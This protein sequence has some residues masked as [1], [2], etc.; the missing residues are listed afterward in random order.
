[1]K[2]IQNLSPRIVAMLAVATVT[3]AAC[4]DA[5]PVKQGSPEVAVTSVAPRAGAPGTR[6]AINGAGFGTNAGNVHVFVGGRQ[7]TVIS[8]ADAAVLVEIPIDAVTGEMVVQVCG[9]SAHDAG[10]FNV[11]PANAAN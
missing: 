1:M 4:N 11:T 9:R 6:V 7:L 10:R 2:I 3:L 8:V 5:I